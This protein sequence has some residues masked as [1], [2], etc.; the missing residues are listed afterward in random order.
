MTNNLESIRGKHR[1]G[2][3]RKNAG[4]K[5]MPASKKPI[6]IDGYV[7]TEI[8]E[9]FRK[10]VPAA[11]DRKRLYTQWVRA[12][13]VAGGETDRLLAQSPLSLRLLNYLEA[14]GTPEAED[15]AEELLS[16]IVTRESDE[17]KLENGAIKLRSSSA[18]SSASGVPVASK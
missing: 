18:K 13:V 11:A 16:L 6:N 1:G 17:A 4:R 9:G 14:T 15:L 7:A 10:L 3:S 12:Y 5:P 2:G 8:I